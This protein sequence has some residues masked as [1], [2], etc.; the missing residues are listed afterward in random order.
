[1]R[2][3]GDKADAV[4]KQSE[5]KDDDLTKLVR[6]DQVKTPEVQA[7]QFINLE[8]DQKQQELKIRSEVYRQIQQELEPQISKQTA[9]LKKEAY[10]EAK[11]AGFEDGYQAGFETGQTQ[12]LEKAQQTAKDSLEPKVARIESLLNEL[13]QPQ[14]LV[15]LKV[16]DQL[17]NL[18]LMLAEKL[19]EET[20]QADKK[21]IIRFVEEAVAK[22]PDEE[23]QIT[24]ELNPD[25]VSV[26]E[27]YQKQHS[28]NWKLVSNP[29]LEVG[30][31]RAKSLN[32]VIHH[33]WKQNLTSFFEQTDALITSLSDESSDQPETEPISGESMSS[34][35][36]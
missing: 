24:L 25:D 19:V 13:A 32:S 3:P 2:S 11:Q 16:F 28:K 12:G 4:H 21:R 34:E 10:E 17:A 33:N 18:A 26:L 9:I 7:W 23:A 22:L 1:M 5:T 15:T 30:T 20:I 6:A 31:C 29:A 14:K 35:K 36:E 27:Y 8:Q